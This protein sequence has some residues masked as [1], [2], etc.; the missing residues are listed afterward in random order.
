MSDEATVVGVARGHWT[1][2]CLRCEW[3]YSGPCRQVDMA[4]RA[5]VAGCGGD[6]NAWDQGKNLVLM[7]ERDVLGRVVR[8]PEGEETPE[9]TGRYTLNGAPWAKGHYNRPA[10]DGDDA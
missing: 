10:F 9:T 5:H 7:L 6:G 2:R 1:S 8:R 4:L 3:T